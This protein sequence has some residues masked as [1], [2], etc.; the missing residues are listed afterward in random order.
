MVIIQ[1]V[2]YFLIKETK[3][4]SFKEYVMYA[5][6]TTGPIIGYTTV[7]DLAVGDYIEIA[8]YQNSG[9]TLSVYGNESFFWAY[10]LGA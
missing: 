10:Y 6:A 1:L 5:T 7:W 4:G 8:A 2:Q 3:N 9:S